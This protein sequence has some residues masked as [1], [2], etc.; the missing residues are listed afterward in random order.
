MIFLSQARHTTSNNINQYSYATKCIY[1]GMQMR[2]I[3]FE[4]SP[5]IRQCRLEGKT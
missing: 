1:A 4:L 2:H 3:I 5:S